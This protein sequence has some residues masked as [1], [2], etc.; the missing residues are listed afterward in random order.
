VLSESQTKSF[1]VRLDR[2]TTADNVIPQIV[3]AGHE[4]LDAA[5]EAAQPGASVRIFNPLASGA[6]QDVSCASVLGG[7]G[8]TGEA[9]AALVSNVSDEPIGTAPQKLTPL[10]IVCVLGGLAVNAITQYGCERNYPND[11]ACPWVSTVGSWGFSSA[12]CS[13]F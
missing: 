4:Q 8:S 13:L 2:A 5:C 3:A 7:D 11:L 12:V 10:A 1:A 6:Y 9:S